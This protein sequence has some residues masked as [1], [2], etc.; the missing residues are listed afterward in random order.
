MGHARVNHHSLAA[1]YAA[2]SVI[3]PRAPCVPALLGCFP[4]GVMGSF[5]FLLRPR[6]MSFSGLL[7]LISLDIIYHIIYKVKNVIF[8]LLIYSKEKLLPRTI[9]AYPK[10]LAS[11]SACQW[12]QFWGPLQLGCH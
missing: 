1:D 12:I 9:P 3:E 2:Q 10:R 8:L 5:R 6:L 7:S 4:L 11:L